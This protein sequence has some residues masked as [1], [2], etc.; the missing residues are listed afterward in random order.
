MTTPSSNIDQFVQEIIAIDPTFA[1][2]KDEVRRVV[3]ELLT[4]EP[5]T[6]PNP[7]FVAK[8]RQALLEKQPTSSHSFFSFFMNNKQFLAVSLATLVVAVGV[9]SYY[10]RSGSSQVPMNNH[11]MTYV[12]MSPQAF[13]SLVGGTS[14]VSMRESAP[15]AFSPAAPMMARGQGGGG[16][17][18]A[19]DAK[20]IAPN[21]VEY[22]Y[23]YEGTDGFLP[24]NLDELSV[25][26]RQK[27]IRADGQ[28]IFSLAD[29]FF[30]NINVRPLAGARVQNVNLVQD[31]KEGYSMYVDFDDARI[32]I[33]P[34]YMQW[35]GATACGGAPCATNPLTV[36][37]VPSDDEL[38][39][40]ANQFLQEYDV[41]MAQYGSPVVDHSW[42]TYTNDADGMQY[43][44]DTLSVIYPLVLGG[45]QIMEGYGTLPFGLRVNVDLRRNKVQGMWNV[46]GGSFAESTY[47]LETDEARI[48]K[49]AENGGYIGPRY[50]AEGMTVTK[51]TVR[52]GTPTVV[53]QQQF[54]YDD[55]SQTSKELYVPALSFP[56][57]NMSDLEPYMQSTVV[58]PLP[59]ELL[60]SR[61]QTDMPIPMPVDGPV[62]ILR[63]A[64]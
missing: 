21:P 18:V 17:G 15:T 26:L 1:E 38:I 6:E 35:Y 55:A 33:S 3:E 31:T 32:S 19:M 39:R 64:Q 60:D 46:L 34:N 11:S 44:P 42:K 22:T 37:D 53:Y 5:T 27:N 50:Y 13:G 48:K 8:L 57:T 36:N 51:K 56:V 43:V 30:P 23:I 54:I 52:L 58:V 25:F 16:G 9:G 45:N 63:E 4:H 49:F 10:I 40:I 14:D 47:P 29:R 41:D 2:K 7:F 61:E 62:T 28:S 12:A 24:A 59:K 20:M